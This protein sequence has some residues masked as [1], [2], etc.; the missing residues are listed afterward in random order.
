M[1]IPHVR[2]SRILASWAVLTLAAWAL[3]CHWNFG[4]PAEDFDPGP[5][6]MAVL[7]GIAAIVLLFFTLFFGAIFKQPPP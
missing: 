7:V 5:A 4:L 1:R 2:L 6:G 3:C